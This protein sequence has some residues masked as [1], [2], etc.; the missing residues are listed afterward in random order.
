MAAERSRLNVAL[1]R[2]GSTTINTSLLATTRVA[3]LT[4]TKV[5]WPVLRIAVPGGVGDCA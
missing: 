5:A 2:G 1:E 4:F 3:P